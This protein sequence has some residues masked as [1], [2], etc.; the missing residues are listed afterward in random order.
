MASDGAIRYAYLKAGNAV[1]EV[2][3][4]GPAPTDLPDGGPDAY[5]AHFLK[6]AAGQRALVMSVHFGA[7]SANLTAT[8]KDESVKLGNVVVRSYYWYSR[9]FSRLGKIG[10]RPLGTFVTRIWTSVKI[11]YHLAAFRPHRVLCGLA[12]F[13]LWA[14]FLSTRLLSIPLICSRHTRFVTS[15]EP[16]YRRAVATVDERIMRR[17]AAVVCHGPYLR[18]QVIELG[19]A[20]ERVIDFAWGFRDM[21]QSPRMIHRK[22]NG[23]GTYKVVLFLGRIESNKGIFDLLDACEPILRSNPAV[24]LVYAGN[25]NYLDRLRAKVA[26]RSLTGAVMLPR[27]DSSR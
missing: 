12:G 18:Q 11:F 3:R 21:Q 2:R 13:P 8:D 9:L 15:S 16:W 22:L 25:G 5:L 23:G 20:P 7:G 14:A 1:E 24:R 10:T 17:A 26:H 27:N 6:V 19:I 4:L